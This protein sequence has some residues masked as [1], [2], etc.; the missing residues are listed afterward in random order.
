VKFDKTAGED[1][2]K[3]CGSCTH[4]CVGEGLEGMK[5]DIHRHLIVAAQRLRGDEPI[6][7]YMAATGAVADNTRASDTAIEEPHVEEVVAGLYTSHLVL[8]NRTGNLQSQV[9]SLE[10]QVAQLHNKVNEGVNKF[11][12]SSCPLLT[13]LHGPYFRH[14]PK[15]NSLKP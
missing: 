2:R 11:P 10:E 13:P 4:P 3:L 7:P 6:P 8:E 12:P 14:R 15:P 9:Q 5:M 1:D